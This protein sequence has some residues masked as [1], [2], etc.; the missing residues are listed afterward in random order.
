MWI[1][2]F[3]VSTTA[4]SLVEKPPRER[5]RA[6]HRTPLF[7]P[8]H[9]GV[10]ERRSHRLLSRSHRPRSVVRGRSLPSGPAS[11]SS[12]SGCR[13]SSTARNARANRATA[14]RSS[15]GKLPPRRRADHHASLSVPSPAEAEPVAVEPIVR[16][17]KHDDACRSL[18]TPPIAAQ[19]PRA[20]ICQVIEMI[21]VSGLTN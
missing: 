17:L 5:P 8:T 9:P 19:L 20:A 12:R 16:R 13:R 21:Y 1:G 10:R 7:R 18:I 2:L 6:L 3:S 4:W 11:P 15:P 14:G